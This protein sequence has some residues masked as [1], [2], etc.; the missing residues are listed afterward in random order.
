MHS[1]LLVLLLAALLPLQALAEPLAAAECRRL[2]ERRNQLAAEA[3][4]VEIALV[5]S[6]RRQLCPQQEAVAEQANAHSPA[7]AKAHS[8]A[9]SSA[10]SDGTGSES[11]AGSSEANADPQGHASRP[12]TAGQ[13][14]FDYTAYLQC[15][16]QAEQRLRRSRAILYTNRRGFIF[17]TLEGSRLAREADAWQ[18]RLSGSCAAEGG[19]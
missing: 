2:R 5:Q 10:G 1:S 6:T 9:Q 16:Q 7:P 11:A 19:G 3:M 14:E 4:Q 17:Y 18:Q 13:D 12:S 8:D 15:R